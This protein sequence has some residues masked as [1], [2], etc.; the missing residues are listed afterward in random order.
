MKMNKPDIKQMKAERNIKELMEALKDKDK[1][2]FE[3]KQ[4]QLL[5][6]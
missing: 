6:K 5:A 2:G 3:S 4:R 1:N